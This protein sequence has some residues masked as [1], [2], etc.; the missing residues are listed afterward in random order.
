MFSTDVFFVPRLTSVQ[1]SLSLLH[2]IVLFFFVSM[3]WCGAPFFVF[4][5]CKGVAIVKP[6]A[7]SIAVTSVFCLNI[8]KTVLEEFLLKVAVRILGETKE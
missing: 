6:L 8:K 2:S 1:I 3:R 4:I 7:K 5:F